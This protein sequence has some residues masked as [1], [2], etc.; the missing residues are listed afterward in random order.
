MSNDSTLRIDW[1]PT[2]RN[3]TGIASARINGSPAIFTQKIDVTV[4]EAREAFIA[5]VL[6]KRKGLDRVAVEQALEE[7]AATALGGDEIE[8]EKLSAGQHVTKLAA[9]A[10]LFRCGETPYASID[11]TDPTGD[12]HIETYPV[13]SLEFRRW[14]ADRFYRT[15]GRP[16]TTAATNDAVETLSAKAMY[17]GTQRKVAVRVAELD[18]A[19][20]LDLTDD[21]WRVVRV[22]KKG[23][24]IIKDSPVKFLRKRGMLPLAAPVHGGSV[25][26]L[27][28]LLNIK[29]ERHFILLIGWLL[30]ALHPR[31]PYPT[32]CV[33]GEHGSAKSTATKM[34]RM[35]IDPNKAIVRSLPR[36]ERDLMI[37][38]SNSWICAYDNI[39]GMRRWVSD[40]LCCLAT[41]GGFGTRMLHT[42]DAEM[43]FD[44]KRPVILNGI[45]EDATK[46]DLLDRSIQVML[47]SIGDEER[48]TEEDIWGDFALVAP[49]VLGALLDATA[50]ALKNVDK[51]KLDRLPRMA[52]FAKWVVAA[53][54]ELSWPAGTFMKAYGGNRDDADESVIEQS[55]IGPAIV[56]LM[57]AADL[58]T[59]NGTISELYQAVGNHAD[60]SSKDSDDWP[61]T[62]KKFGAALKRIEPTLRRH[63]GINVSKNQRDGQRRLVMLTKNQK[64]CANFVTIVTS[65]QDPPLVGQK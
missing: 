11:V 46:E 57:D 6:R 58:G 53:E 15:F 21:S 22:T 37:Q 1:K 56:A 52:D 63:K 30:S 36:D 20:Y 51:V 13:G 28:P 29:E 40:A 24:S 9:A 49:E 10:E 26:L 59:W 41:G 55:A 47:S 65:S 34:L 3:G 31:G 45:E 8:Q 43:L 7:T 5:Q 12:H 60:Q 39:S 38:A 48:R 27:R 19:I 50:A 4:L 35:L 64:V 18:G 44:V 2:G 54:E 33:N 25:N 42:D 17:N 16:A 14:L 61:S 23:W 32:L 62:S